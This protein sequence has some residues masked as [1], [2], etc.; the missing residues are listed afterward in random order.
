MLMRRGYTLVEVLVVVTILGIAGAI[1]V[2]SI[3]STNVLRIQSAVRTIVADITYAQ[4]DALAYQER[5]ALVFDDDTN[6]Y[7]LVEV[8][9]G[10]IDVENNTMFDPQRPGGRYRVDMNL[11]LFG[12]TRLANVDFDGTSTLIFDAIGGPVAGP[13]SDTPSAGGSIDLIGTDSAFRIS[14]E[15]FTGRVQVA[16]L[17]E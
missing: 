16:R 2:P 14:V 12:D 1:V 13:S 8:V 7:S 3:G 5:R 4:T 11:P 10:V 15:P 17:P 9:N 6:A